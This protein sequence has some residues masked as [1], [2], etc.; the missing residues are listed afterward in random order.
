MATRYSDGYGCRRPQQKV[1]AAFEQSPTLTPSINF[2]NV[3]SALKYN[4][5]ASDNAGCPELEEH[6]P[7]LV[8]LLFSNGVVI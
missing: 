3:L 7:E 5:N 4:P 8:M 6:L 1:G 2:K